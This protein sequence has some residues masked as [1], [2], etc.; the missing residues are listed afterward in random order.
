MQYFGTGFCDVPPMPPATSFY[1]ASIGSRCFL[2]AAF[3]AL[4]A[5][6]NAVRTGLLVL[7][8]INLVG[9]LTM[10]IALRKGSAISSHG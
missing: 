9:A 7:A 1:M 4:A 10:S 8:A 5:S 3:S 2:A 6:H